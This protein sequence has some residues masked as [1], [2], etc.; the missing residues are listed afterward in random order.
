[1]SNE[2]V[3]VTEE[4][5]AAQ[6][7]AA[8]REIDAAVNASM[9]ANLVDPIKWVDRPWEYRAWKRT[10]QFVRWVGPVRLVLFFGRAAKVLVLWSASFAYHHARG[11][12]SSRT[13]FA[14]LAKCGACQFQEKKTVRGGILLFCR[15]PK[16]GGCGGMAPCPQTRYSSLQRKAWLW[17]FECP[18]GKF[19][20]GNR[21]GAE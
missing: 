1:M 18:V 8:Q 10:E 11:R 13:A 19:G 7:F 17:N 6:H 12:V 16:N 3:Q 20:T 4:E 14:R 5:Y 9:K 15:G 21:T 2:A